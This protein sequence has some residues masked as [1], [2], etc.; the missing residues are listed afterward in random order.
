MSPIGI[1]H[2]E[3]NLDSGYVFA[4]FITGDI[5]LIDCNEAEKIYPDNMYERS[6]LDSLIHSDPAAYVEL[7]LD[8]DVEKHLKIA[9]QYVPLRFLR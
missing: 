9:T 7:I 4:K 1:I 2:A 5:V 6:E 3:Y 8:N